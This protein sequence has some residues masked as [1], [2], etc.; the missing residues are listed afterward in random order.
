LNIVVDT[1][2]KVPH[3]VMACPKGMQ[4]QLLVGWQWVGGN[5]VSFLD[6]LLEE[7]ICV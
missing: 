3:G 5:T 2:Q 4:S 7:T 6:A 1:T